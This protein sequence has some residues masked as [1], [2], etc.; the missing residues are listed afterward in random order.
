MILI[1]NSQIFSQQI[2]LNDKGDTLNCLTQTQSKFL[3]K[4][5][6]E[7]KECDTLLSI[8]K[9][10]LINSKKIITFKDLIITDKDKIISGRDSL[11][12]IKDSEI[13]IYKEQLKKSKREIKKQKFY[14]TIWFSTTV[15]ALILLIIL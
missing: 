10:E 7:K 14:K 2:I 4:T 9:K 5:Y 3:I 8:Y 6:Y 15:A 1:T 11:E 12:I 13:D